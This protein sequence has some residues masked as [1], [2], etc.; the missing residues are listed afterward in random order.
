M[1][2]SKLQH[3]RY[4]LYMKKKY[5]SIQVCILSSSI[6]LK[7]SMLVSGLIVDFFKR[8]DV[9]SNWDQSFSSATKYCVFVLRYFLP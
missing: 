8:G 3:R 6:F 2:Y 5:Y 4:P 7:A 1:K 9:N